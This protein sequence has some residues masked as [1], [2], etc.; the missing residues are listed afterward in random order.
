MSN[1]SRP[2]LLLVDD[3]ELLLNALVRALRPTRRPVLVATTAENARSQLAGHEVGVIICEPR[4][5]HLA[6]FLIE[7]RERHPGIV[8]VLLTGYPDLSSVLTTVNTA[9]PFKLLTKPWIDAELVATVKLAL[10]QYGINLQREQL[11]EDYAGI[12]ANSESA[13]AF[14][15]LSAMT[16]SVH[17]D[18]SAAAVHDLPV[19][20]LLLQNGTVALVNPAAQHLLPKLGL[21]GP[22]LGIAVQD[23]PPMLATLVTAA[24]AAPRRQRVRHQIP[25][26]GRYDFFALEIAGGT[27]IAFAPEPQIGHRSQL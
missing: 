5:T 4:D 14:R 10:K 19:G 13:H 21:P 12:R 3:D 1:A 25:G 16:H 15:M 23:L 22:A 2:H 18:M 7:A 17:P 8:R 6:A 27:L 11:M 9:H 26:N 20:A 24:L